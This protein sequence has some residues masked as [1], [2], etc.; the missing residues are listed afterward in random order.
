M[1]SMFLWIVMFSGA[2]VL[3][4]GV[5]LVSSERE[6][7]KKRGEINQ[8]LDRLDAV[9]AP[10][11]GAN[12]GAEVTGLRTKTQELLKEIAT[13]QDDLDAAHRAIDELRAGKPAP[14]NDV[15]L[16]QVEQ[17]RHANSQLDTQVEELRDRL[18]ASEAR[19][20]GSTTVDSDSQQRQAQLENSLIELK[21]QLERS[22]AR[23]RE[24]ES[25]PVPDSELNAAQQREETDK[26]EARIVQLEQSLNSAAES[27]CQAD[28]LRQRLAES[29]KS[30]Q[31]L[32]DTLRQRDQEL[33]RW[34]EQ[35]AASE[36]IKQR[37]LALQPVYSQLV[38]KQSALI[39]HQRA[40]HGEL[41]SFAEFLSASHDGT[42]APTVDKDS[43]PDSAGV[44]SLPTQLV[45]TPLAEANGQATLAAHANGD[46]VAS[47]SQAKAGFGIFHALIALVVGGALVALFLSQSSTQPSANAAKPLPQ[48]APAQK[49]APQP[50]SPPSEVASADAPA[51]PAVE[52]PAPVKDTPK[53][54]PPAA[55]A[56][57]VVYQVTQPTRVFAAPAEYAQ[58]VGEIEPGLKVTVVNA[59]DGWL[60]I[61]SKNGRPPGFIRSHTAARIDG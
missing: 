21:Q 59:R 9:P 49:P 1:E 19:M 54:I 24:L 6:L 42:I 33:P 56:A 37:L 43:N 44:A 27:A 46:G 3:L 28:L 35:L 45:L 26:L 12:N 40:Y 14:T 25:A 58:Q 36:E 30:A 7:K 17:L 22:Q 48:S 47:A 10:T 52:A 57:A 32:R 2:A 39:D 18:Q 51:K 15:T 61:H 13:L 20:A 4:L 31:E 16:A 38:A 23:V 50:A 53:K 5:F 34:R 55:V 8:L 29:E 60:E 41:K 11:S